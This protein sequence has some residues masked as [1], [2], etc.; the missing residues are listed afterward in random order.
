MSKKKE[1]KQKKVPFNV[2]RKGAAALALA[3]VMIA[4]PFMLTGCSGE[5]GDTGEQGSKGEQGVQG[6]QGE[7]GKG[8]VDVDI[9]YEYDNKG[10]LYAVY[11]FTYTDG[12]TS[13]ER[14]LV[15]KRMTALCGIGLSE[16]DVLG[17]YVKVADE[18]S[19]P[20]LY[21]IVEFEDGTKGKVALTDDMFVVKDGLVIPDFT[22]KG[23][24]Q[25]E[26]SYKGKRIYSSVDIV[27]FS[28]LAGQQI[29]GVGL[30]DQTIV[31][32]TA[33][34]DIT[35]VVN[36][37]GGQPVYAPVSMVAE[38]YFA[39]NQ[40]KEVT[41][42]DTSLVDAYNITLKTEFCYEMDG[43]DYVNEIGTLY[44]YSKDCTVN[45][46]DVDDLKLD[47]GDADFETKIKA[48]KF[49][50]Y[51]FEPNADGE[52]LIQGTV[53]DLSYDLSSF[54]IDRVGTYLIPF[55]Y[56][57][58]GQTGVYKDTI[59][60]S[61]ETE[62]SPST[63][64]ETYTV[65]GA[66]L[67]MFEMTYGNTVELHEDGVA[68]LYDS[69]EK[70][71]SQQQASYEL[72]DSGT[73]LK[74]Y[75]SIMNAYAYYDVDDTN[76]KVSAFTKASGTPTEFTGRIEMLG[77]LLDIKLSSYGTTGHA[78]A[79]VTIVA[80]GPGGTPVETPYAFI[81]CNWVDSD[82]VMFGNRTFNVTTGNVL[83]EV[84]E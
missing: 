45:Y 57:L 21:L 1:E 5:K 34:K 35:V 13:E 22:K 47:L 11:T 26:V 29:N 3:G 67:P 62:L 37:E 15:P 76:N 84:T 10:D 81:D 53:E 50:G 4:S 40:M 33:A 77:L 23:H 14:V 46:I 8:V 2:F 74:I 25:F 60:I 16:N 43:G 83:E 41:T 39:T 52:T 18:A 56:Q 48:L 28:D 64:L 51:L 78:M 44:L 82:T 69:A 31:V 36:Y 72:I 59:E 20:T 75:D 54:N 73:T 70:E 65:D 79:L 80:P 7:A 17:Q 27:E 32:G 30:V 55:T 24:Q 63:L 19:A 49:S 12:T 42:L 68:L 71:E 6:I 66:T 61:V 9:I 38:K 58:E